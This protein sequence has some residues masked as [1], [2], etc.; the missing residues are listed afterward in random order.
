[1]RQI[2]CMKT[3]A[4]SG[5][6]WGTLNRQAIQGLGD[7]R[8]IERT[9]LAQHYAEDTPYEALTLAAAQAPNEAALSYF[10]SAHTMHTPYVVRYREL[11]ANIIRAANTF[12]L[13]GINRDDVVAYL[14]PNIPETHFVIWG[15]S[16]VGVVLGLDPALGSARIAEALNQSGAKVLV[17]LEASPFSDLW[18]IASE[19]V[20]LAPCV[21][22]VLVCNYIPYIQEGLPK[23]EG[24]EL[25]K[26]PKNVLGSGAKVRRYWDVVRP[27]RAD[28]L[29][30]DGP[31][32]TDISSLQITNDAFEPLRIARI[33]HRA[34]VHN[35]WAIAQFQPAAFG[36]GLMSLCGSRLY[37]HSAALLN[38]LLPWM[39]GG[40]VLLAGPSGFQSAEVS[41]QFRRLIERY[42]VS[43]FTASAPTFEAL[44]NEP[45]SRAKSDSV[46][47]AIATGMQ[48]N[49]GL[50]AKFLA[51][52]GIPLVEAYAVVEA[53]AIASM[54]PV[55]SRPESGSLGIRLPHQGLSVAIVA[56][57]GEFMRWAQP[58]ECG[59]VFI[60]G[61][62]LFEGYLGDPKSEQVTYLID[63]ISWFATGDIGSL[64]HNGFLRLEEPNSQTRSIQARPASQTY[65]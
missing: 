39:F 2:G 28:R 34:E 38:G 21:E 57:T 10:F 64:D 12:S 24:I 47:L 11:L 41:N 50:S 61:P 60:S 29:I 58:G 52:T 23:P 6:G 55:G 40:H 8:R 42:R 31:K 32:G 19:A 4:H 53:T 59:E 17:T 20:A 54:N 16:T 63:E 22:H 15:G 3:I 46:Q 44:L 18:Q 62:N 25:S 13:L 45:D 36:R 35:C 49:P 27:E 65:Q 48:S 9:S 33:S 7:V 26:P 1:M 14:L 37:D 5:N 56:W 51:K 43:T 30:V